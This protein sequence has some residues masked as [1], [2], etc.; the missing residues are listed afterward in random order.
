MAE[1]AKGPWEIG[2][3][4]GAYKTEIVARQEDG[5]TKV[6]ALVTTHK[7][8]GVLRDEQRIVECPEGIANLHKIAAAQEMLEA[9]QCVL[10]NEASDHKAQEEFG[11]YVLDDNVRRVVITAIAKATGAAPTGNGDR[12]ELAD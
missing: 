3:M 6:I 2:S 9:L 4:Y 8:E 12:N 1:H 10:E 7:Q 11:G 5:P